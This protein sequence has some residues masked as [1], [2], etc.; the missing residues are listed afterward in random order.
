MIFNVNV[1]VSLFI[2]LPEM[3]DLKAYEPL[4]V[5]EGKNRN[6][7]LLQQREIRI[8]QDKRQFDMVLWK[9][10]RFSKPH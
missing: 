5:S 1:I 8:T 6:R 7:L 4:K 9:T 2:A 10:F 3:A